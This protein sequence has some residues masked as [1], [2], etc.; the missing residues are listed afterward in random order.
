MPNEGLKLTPEGRALS[1]EYSIMYNFAV[2]FFHA[3]FIGALLVMQIGAAP[4]SSGKLFEGDI[5][6]SWFEKEVE[7][8]K[9]S[10]QNLKRESRRALKYLWRTRV[11]PYEISSGEFT[12]SE[13]DSIVSALKIFEAKT[14]LTFVLRSTQAHWI[15]FQKLDG[16]YSP[17]GRSFWRTGFQTISLAQGCL[18]QST[19]LHE[20]MHSLGFWHEQSRPDRDNYIEILWENIIDDEKYNFEK[21]THLK[22]DNLG[23]NYDYQTLMH[24]SRKAFSKNGQPTMKAIGNENLELGTSLTLSESDIVQINAMYDCKSKDISIWSRWSEFSPCDTYCDK[25]RQRFCSHD[26]LTQ[27][28]NADEHG[29]IT[30]TVRCTEAECNVP[31]DGHWGRWSMWSDCDKS[32]GTGKKT[33]TRQCND[34]VP[35]HGGKQCQGVSTSSTDCIIKSCGLGIYDCEFETQGWCMWLRDPNVWSTYQW[36]RTTGSTPTVNSG[37]SGDHTTGNGHYLYVEASAPGKYG[38][39]ARI[40][41]KEMPAVPNGICLSFWYHMFG[42]TMGSLRVFI[43]SSNNDVETKL[44]EYSGDKGNQ[45]LS[46]N[47]TIKSESPFKVIFEAENGEAYLSDMALDDIKFKDGTC[48]K[49]LIETKCGVNAKPLGCYAESSSNRLFPEMLDNHREGHDNFIIDWDNFPKSV[50]SILCHCAQRAKA[51]GYKYFGIQYYA[52]CWSGP[53]DIDYKRYGDSEKCVDEKYKP[54]STAQGEICAGENNA[55]YVYQ[56]L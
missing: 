53:G 38:D 31:V 51:R 46:A 5:V 50:E 24:Y 48:E 45:W 19:I 6:P 29:I 9:V 17:V 26:D 33:R 16:C 49:S 23:V 32:C 10:T 36:D 30:E 37:P 40:I 21:Y 34:P 41:S 1:E 4:E 12:Q 22:A 18:G 55:N 54:C 7:K 3:C 11:V 8:G 20:V 14:C 13:Q 27:C 44:L 39:K 28:I 56:I 42:K 52:E 15:K 35:K 25:R 47:K 43:R 2:L